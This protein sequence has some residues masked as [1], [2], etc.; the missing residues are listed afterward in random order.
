MRLFIAEKPSVANAIAAELGNAK[1]RGSHIETD[2]GT[3]TWCFGHLLE[4][5][6]PEHYDASLKFWKLDALPIVPKQWALL[7]KPDS[8]DQL[9]AIGELLSKASEI[10]NAGDPDR[11]G[12]LLVDEVLEHFDNHKPVKRLWLAAQ[13]SGSVRKALDGISDNAKFQPLKNMALARARA[14]WLVGMNLTRAYTVK[15][16][17]AGGEGVQSVGRVQTP[18]L[19]LVVARDREIENFKASS[20]Y[21]LTATVQHANGSFK[22]KWKAPEGAAGLDA[23]GRL[24]DKAVAEAIGQR[25]NGKTGRISKAEKKQMAEQQPK[26]FALSTLTIKANAKY[27]Y[28]AEQVLNAAQSLYETHKITSYPRTD[29]VY[30]P[31]SQYADRAAVIAAIRNN[32]TDVASVIAGADQ[33][34]RSPV[35]DDE[36]VTAHHGIAP[37]MHKADTSKLTA[38]EKHIYDMVTLAYLAQFYPEHRYEQT[39]IAVEVEK[40][41]FTASGRISLAEGWKAVFKFEDEADAA[42]EAEDESQKLPSVAQ[43]DAAKITGMDRGDKKTKAPPAFTEGLLVKAMS[44]IHAY[45]T[46]PEHKRILKE[47]SGIGTEATRAAIIKTL[48]TREFIELKGKKVKSTPTGRALIDTLPLE[49]KDPGLTAMFEDKLRSIEDGSLTLDAF[50]AEQIEYLN[51]RVGAAKSATVKRAPGIACP[52]CGKE[53]SG[54][55]RQIKGDKGVFWGC[56]RYREGCKASFPDI[57][58]KPDLQAKPKTAAPPTPAMQP[59]PTC[60]K[61]HGGQLRQITT[62]KGVFW[63]CTR[64]REGCKTSFNDA[65]GKPDIAG[66]K[67][68]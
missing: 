48:K 5:A 57:K 42:P 32:N 46:N 67:G 44:N 7:P 2:K 47:T 56:T 1:K 68:A 4:Q 40:D 29:C 9:A 11:E 3:V 65:N 51:T 34:I 52:A 60:N 63:G 12:Q 43:G 64:F 61:D 16:K 21:V 25:V 37:T 33:A 18:T 30:L 13:D 58:G 6:P 28:S 26:L 66:R 23:E 15:N 17:M 38:I 20:Y 45:V 59:C 35:W 8:K 27:G 41:T 10:V 55:L 49:I 14:D 19:A 53:H 39:S 62:A 36:K 50:L 54:E 24:T 31:E 22:A